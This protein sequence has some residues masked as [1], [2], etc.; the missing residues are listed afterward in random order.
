M[1]ASDVVYGV[2]LTIV[3]I[4]ALGGFCWWSGRFPEKTAP[5]AAAATGQDAT[6]PG[7]G[8]A[9]AVPVAMV[10]VIGTT[11]EGRR[12]IDDPDRRAR[13]AKITRAAEITRAARL[14]QLPNLLLVD[15]DVDDAEYRFVVTPAAEPSPRETLTEEVADRMEQI[16]AAP[17]VPGLQELPDGTLPPDEMG[18]TQD[19]LDHHLRE[20]HADGTLAWKDV[21]AVAALGLAGTGRELRR[22]LVA[23]AAYALLWAEQIESRPPPV[24]TDETVRY[25]DQDETCMTLRINGKPMGCG[26]CRA[27]RAREGAQ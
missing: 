2:G 20:L 26:V 4:G 10:S 21:L 12:E 1:D 14:D 11:P 25:A 8:D 27:C 6:S 13:V 16:A 17:P 18:I 22:P 7:P 15:Q 23:L 9:T 24:W 5:A 19:W 3:S